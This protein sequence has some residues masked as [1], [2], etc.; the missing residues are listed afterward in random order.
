MNLQKNT[1]N[2]VDDAKTKNKTKKKTTT[3]NPFILL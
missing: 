2:N 3:G 1:P